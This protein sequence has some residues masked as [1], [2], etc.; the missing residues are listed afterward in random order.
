M[1]HNMEP[2]NKAGGGGA[3]N[4]ASGSSQEGVSA[5]A[6]QDKPLPVVMVPEK[7]SSFKF[8]PKRFCPDFCYYFSCTSK[9]ELM[10]S[11][12]ILTLL[13]ALGHGRPDVEGQKEVR[14]DEGDPITTTVNSAQ[15]LEEETATETPTQKLQESKKPRRAVF[16]IGDRFPPT[17]PEKTK[18]AAAAET[19]RE[20]GLATGSEKA[21]T[22]AEK[23]TAA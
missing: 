21:G 18:A 10:K 8:H 20:N 4:Q 19:S 1:P 15:G 16:P 12:F 14:R 13:F 7:A 22:N 6:E 17:S 2:E 3:S 9:V 23:I 11:I 5:S